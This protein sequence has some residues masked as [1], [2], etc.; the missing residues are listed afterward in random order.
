MYEMTAVGV[1]EEPP[2]NRLRKNHAGFTM[3]ELM[4]V[5]V[6]VGILAAIAI[7]IYGKYVRQARTTEATARIGEIVT[8]S[9][10]W[11]QENETWPTD[12]DL[13]SGKGV[14]DPTSTENFSY[15]IT[16]GGAD[17]MQPFE[18]TATGT[19]EKMQGVVVKMRLPDINST[20]AIDI[21]SDQGGQTGS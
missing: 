4:V 16:E 8:A 6:I 15:R 9:K 12:A 18:V 20:G 17:K 19:G 5:V 1:L 10:S 14:L 13:Q 11:A 7:P 21:S 3:I 2:M